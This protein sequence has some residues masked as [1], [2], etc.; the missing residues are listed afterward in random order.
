MHEY[1]AQRRQ[2]VHPFPI[3]QPH[4]FYLS[5]LKQHEILPFNLSCMTSFVNSFLDIYS[6]RITSHSQQQQSFSMLHTYARIWQFGFWS[7]KQQ[8]QHI[9]TTIAIEDSHYL[10]WVAS[11]FCSHLACFVCRWLCVQHRS[12]HT[13]SA[14]ATHIRSVALLIHISYVESMLLLTPSITQRDRM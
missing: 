1:H 10:A 7:D 13:P 4:T 14:V 5:Q 2:T 6:L 12:I 9:F 8:Q 3:P 11:F